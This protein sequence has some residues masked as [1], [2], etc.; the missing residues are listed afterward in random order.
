MDMEFVRD[1]ITR[2][3]IQS[4]KSEYQLSYDLGHS[5]NYIHNIVNGYSQP[6]VKEL[7]YLIEILGTTPREFFD[8]AL[9]GASALLVGQISEILHTLDEADLKLL[10]TL[11][12]RL[13][14]EL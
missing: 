1:R 7:L 4:G 14:G 5:K 8:D 2:L 6:S 11:A 12:K 9:S 10:L 13:K 3:R